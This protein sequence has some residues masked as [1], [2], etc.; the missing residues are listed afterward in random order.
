MADGRWGVTGNDQE[1][2]EVSVLV[3]CADVRYAQ[4]DALL[5]KCLIF[6][7]Y[8]LPTALYRICIPPAA[9]AVHVN[10]QL[11]HWSS[12]ISG[13]DEFKVMD[14]IEIVTQR[15]STLESAVQPER[16]SS[17]NFRRVL[18]IT[19][20]IPGRTFQSLFTACS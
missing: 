5:N 7:N 6:H 2:L 14:L 10:L 9:D 4:I 8:R 15:A 1:Q 17:L 13:V 3:M 11:F 16:N 19:P 18:S 12:T 20:L